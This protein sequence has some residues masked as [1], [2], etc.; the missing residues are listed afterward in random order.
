MTR[1]E[2]KGKGESA[3][4]GE[5]EEEG[6]GRHHVAG[7]RGCSLP[8][9]RREATCRGP[10]RLKRKHEKSIIGVNFAR[11][12]Q[13]KKKKT[14]THPCNWRGYG[15]QRAL[16][17]LLMRTHIH[18][19][20]AL[21]LFPPTLPLQ[22]YL[23]PLTEGRSSWSSSSSLSADVKPLKLHPG[24][25]SPY[26]LAEDGLEWWPGDRRI[27]GGERLGRSI[28][29]RGD[30]LCGGSACFSVSILS[31]EQ[32][33]READTSTAIGKERGCQSA[34]IWVEMRR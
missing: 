5:G 10:K 7:R 15:R 13:T 28:R 33:R 21:N 9:I 29:R 16:P 17:L 18:L 8:K 23:P 1:Q 27:A 34:H 2:R 32:E 24:T 25:K 26:G 19:V 22:F 11:D 30:E 3:Q 6:E 12:K 4:G 20:S 14:Y 31:Y